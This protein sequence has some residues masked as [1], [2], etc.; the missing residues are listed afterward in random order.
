MNISTVIP[1]AKH[2]THQQL[3]PLII[4][5]Y[6]IAKYNQ[7]PRKQKDI[8]FQSKSTVIRAVQENI[9]LL[10]VQENIK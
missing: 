9:F 1:H 5:I 6:G 2:E 8:N 3:I 7:H 10:K 4:L